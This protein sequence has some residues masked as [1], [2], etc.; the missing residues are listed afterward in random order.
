MSTL[1]CSSSRPLVPDNNFLSFKLTLNIEY[2]N[3]YQTLNP[4]SGLKQKL[5]RLEGEKIS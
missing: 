4:M 3:M 1:S 2:K 5:I